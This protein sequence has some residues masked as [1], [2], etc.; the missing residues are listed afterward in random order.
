MIG[1]PFLPPVSEREKKNIRKE[2]SCLDGSVTVVNSD[3]VVSARDSDERVSGLFRRTADPDERANP[4]YDCI[5]LRR[6]HS[7]GKRHCPPLQSPWN[8]L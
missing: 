1:A 8:I 6:I 4:Y 2:E 7:K 5:C 3:P